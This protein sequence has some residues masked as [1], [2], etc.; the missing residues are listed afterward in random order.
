[1]L[2]GVFQ[3]RVDHDRRLGAFK[4]LLEIFLGDAGDRHEHVL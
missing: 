1:V 4:T 2:V 3:T